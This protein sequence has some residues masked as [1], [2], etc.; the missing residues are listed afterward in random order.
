MREMMI[1]MAAE[2]AVGKNCSHAAGPFPT[3]V[4][5]APRIRNPSGSMAAVATVDSTTFPRVA[6]T[7]SGYASTHTATADQPRTITPVC[8]ATAWKLSEKKNPIRTS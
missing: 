8:I 5:A 1:A 3:G 7:M 2:T 4:P 6:G